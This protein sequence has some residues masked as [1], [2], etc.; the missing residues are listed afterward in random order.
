MKRHIAIVLFI[1]IVL[2]GS[3]RTIAYAGLKELMEVGKSQADIAK[4]LKKETRNYNSVKDAIISGK[5]EEGMLGDKIRKKYGEP[6][7]E[8]YDEKKDAYK[9]LYMPAT[10][11]HFEG[12]KLYLFIDKEDKL[13][14]WKLV[15]G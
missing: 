3:F 14:G 15:E 6:I 10:S 13:V 4:E 2:T 9:W 11:S 8:I 1:V 12:E 7:I 5:L